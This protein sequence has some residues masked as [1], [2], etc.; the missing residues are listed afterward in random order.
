MTLENDGGLRQGRP[1]FP[2][3]TVNTLKIAGA[4]LI[5]LYFFGAAVIQ[6]GILHVN[7]YTPEQLNEFLAGDAGA[8]LWAGIASMAE[9][10]GM[11]AISIYAYLLAQGVEHTSS[12]K[13]YALSVLVFAAISEVP[14]DLAVYGQAWYWESQNTLWTVFVALITLWIIKYAETRRGAYV[15]SA[16]AALGGCLW[17]E[18][19]RC[20][21]GWGFVLIAVVLYLLR[22]RRTLGLVAGLGVSLVYITAAMGFILISMC[23]GERRTGDSSLGKYAYYAY[24]PLLLILL[25][26]WAWMMQR[27]AV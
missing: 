20:K 22:R 4:I 17:A 7:S 26:V 14:Y 13:R 9:I 23:N 12:M 27:G 2:S 5:T 19:L 8:M 24:Y 18:L 21:Y 3:V 6:N 1:R 11:A 10:T 16:I 25:A 15:F